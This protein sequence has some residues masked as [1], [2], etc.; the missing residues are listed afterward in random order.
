RGET[1]RI[2]DAVGIT[3]FTRDGKGRIAQVDGPDMGTDVNTLSIVY[4][5]FDQ[6]RS[7]SRST[8]TAGQ[9]MAWGFS[10]DGDG[11]L[12]DQTS[13]RGSV[14][15]LRFAYDELDRLVRKYAPNDTNASTKLDVNYTYDQGVR[16]LGRLTQIVGRGFKKIFAYDVRGDVTA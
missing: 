15:E 6:R 12:I 3:T 10:Y 9:Y 5:G 8:K 4:N 13:P 14:R 7:L 1:V 16:K 2:Q 11:N